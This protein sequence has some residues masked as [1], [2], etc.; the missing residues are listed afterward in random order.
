MSKHFVVTHQRLGNGTE[1]R[2]STNAFRSLPVQTSL[3]AV[4]LGFWKII[5]L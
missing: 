3:K 4:N 2:F 1:N 5:F